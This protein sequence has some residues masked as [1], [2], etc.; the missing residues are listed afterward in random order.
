MEIL[1]DTPIDAFNEA[2]A[3]PDKTRAYITGE[4]GEVICIYDPDGQ[5]TEHPVLGLFVPGKNVIAVTTRDQAQ[6]LDA[7]L[8][9]GVLRRA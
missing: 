4:L 8:A 6:A 7:C 1:D 3:P 2:E 9:A 5:P